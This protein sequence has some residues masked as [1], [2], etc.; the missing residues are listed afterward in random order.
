MITPLHTLAHTLSRVLFRGAVTG[1]AAVLTVILLAAPSAVAHAEPLSVRMQNAYAGIGSMRAEFTQQL[2]HKESGSKEQ[3]SGVLTF[4]KPLLVRWETKK[5][6][7]ELLVV[8]K[9]AIWNVFPDEE[10]A[11]KYSLAVAEDSGGI[12]KVVTG[13]ARL[14]QDYDLEDESREGDLITVRLYPRQ[15]SQ[16]LVEAALWI[17]PKTYLIKKI[18]VHDF[19]GNENE[20]VFTRQKTEVAADDAAFSYTPPK[21]F[22]IEDRTRETALEKP[23]L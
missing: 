15:P 11:Y 5:P 2:T 10:L 4:K 1:A 8:G 17:D 21:N 7:P 22:L 3:R 19:Y 6:S 9:D 12:I 13:Q 16:S 14:D 23:L 18:R 20:I